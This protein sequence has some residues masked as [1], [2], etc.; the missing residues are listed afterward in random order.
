MNK[1]NAHILQGEDSCYKSLS[2][3]ID[4]SHIIWMIVV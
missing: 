1:D 2:R 4:L 3:V